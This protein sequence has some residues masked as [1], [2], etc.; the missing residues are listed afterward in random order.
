MQTSSLH[1]TIVA[2][3]KEFKWIDASIW[4]EKEECSSENLLYFHQK[5]TNVQ[6]YIHIYTV[7]GRISKI[8]KKT[9]KMHLSQQKKK[10]ESNL[11]YGPS[12]LLFAPKTFT[13]A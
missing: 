6:E 7:T 9:N 1:R 3:I 8:W 2:S 4:N 12:C 13:G 10:N 11:T 5:S